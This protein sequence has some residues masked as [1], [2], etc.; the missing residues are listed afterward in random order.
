V[1][2]VVA[3]AYQVTILG[4]Y[5]V[6]GRGKRSDEVSEGVYQT[7]NVATGETSFMFGDHIGIICT[8]I[9]SRLKD[10][11]KLFHPNIAVVNVLGL[12]VLGVRS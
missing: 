2:A 3:G 11:E 10:V 12:M 5:V 8:W 4:F 9:L 7:T 6:S 1:F